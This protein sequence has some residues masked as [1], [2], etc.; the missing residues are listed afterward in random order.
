MSNVN[1]RALIGGRQERGRQGSEMRCD[2]LNRG[3]AIQML[4]FKM[5]GTHEAKN[6]CSLSSEKV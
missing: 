5:K 3:P 1:I 6:E 4:V 2:I